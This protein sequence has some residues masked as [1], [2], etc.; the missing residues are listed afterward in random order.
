MPRPCAVEAHA[1]GYNDSSGCG[2]HGLA[3]WRLTL[4]ATRSAAFADATALRRGGSRSRLQGQQRLRMPR[5]CAVEAHARGYKVS[6]VCG[7]HGLAPW[8]LTLAATRSAA[9]ADATALR[10]GGSRSRLQGQQRL[11]MPRPC[12]VE[13]HA[14]GYK[15]SSVCGCHGLAPWRLT[16]AATRSAAFADAT[17]L[18]R[19]GSRSRLQRKVSSVCGCHGLA[20]WRLT[21]IAEAQA[22]LTKSI[23]R[24]TPRRKAVASGSGAAFFLA[25][26]VSLHGARPWHLG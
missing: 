17:A 16:L 10:R 23:K 6:S 26:H 12:A 19:G 20:P 14:R 5:P 8:R 9:F 2:C 22:L 3:P 18:C 25:A 11:R 13:A 4:A 21:F 24:E 7:C 15:V 1:R